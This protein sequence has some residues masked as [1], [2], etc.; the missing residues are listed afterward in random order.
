MRQ[1]YSDRV[2]KNF[3]NPSDFFG[4]VLKVSGDDV[5]EHTIIRFGDISPGDSYNMNNKGEGTLTLNFANE[6]LFW[7]LVNLQKTTP[8]CIER[9]EY[10]NY[11][12]L[13]SNEFNLFYFPS[14]HDY[15]D[16]VEANTKTRKITFQTHTSLYEANT[17]SEHNNEYDFETLPL[18]PNTQQPIIPNDYNMFSWT[19]TIEGLISELWQDNVIN[20]V[21]RLKA[22]A[23]VLDATRKPKGFG[24]FTPA[25]S[26]A[27]GNIEILV[28]KQSILK[29]RDDAYNTLKGRGELQRHIPMI[30]YNSST[31][32]LDFYFIS[33]DD[34][35][36]N[37]GDSL[38]TYT[39]FS[40]S[41]DFTNDLIDILVES[42]QA[43][44]LYDRE[45]VEVKPYEWKL[46][47]GITSG[48]VD[49]NGT[50][51]T[52]DDTAISYAKQQDVIK[53][54]NLSIDFREANF[55]KDIRPAQI[56]TITGYDDLVNGN[57]IVNQLSAIINNT[58]VSY[59]I[60]DM[61][62]VN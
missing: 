33:T 20:P 17:I 34:Y 22:E 25:P 24:T 14:K 31:L 12:S 37:K 21:N 29:I 32:K 46:K 62:E 26:L 18:D 49:E 50:N 3:F 5:V 48:E 43:D 47:E 42:N 1:N 9:F 30:K 54:T 36:I 60:D 38:D 51:S 40:Q 45:V 55:F 2:L 4:R 44:N 15:I 57:Y 23:H 13:G 41:E 19:S 16:N 7:E 6:D 52:F 10:K 58:Y 61:E 27:Q 35:I 59:N 11:L 28:N 8:I 53:A 39:Y 56:I